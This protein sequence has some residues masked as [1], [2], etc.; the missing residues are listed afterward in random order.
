MDTFKK[1]ERLTS[2]IAIK[3]LFTQGRTKMVYPYKIIWNKRPA[4]EEV[5][6]VKI[7]ISVSK[8][9]FKK[10]VDRNKIRRRIKEAYRLHKSQLLTI[11]KQQHLA[12][13]V[14]VIYIA[15]EKQD[16]LFIKKKM[17]KVVQELA[18]PDE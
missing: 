7:V 4:L 5:V 10:A 12:M 11:C 9:N 16:Y 6:P 3:E 2:N 1:E 14:A 17:I 13:N 15:K 8:R 18:L